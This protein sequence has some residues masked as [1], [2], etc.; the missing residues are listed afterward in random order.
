MKRREKRRGQV[1]VTEKE[2]EHVKIAS[3]DKCA[4][5]K[6]EED[7]Q[8]ENDRCRWWGRGEKEDGHRDREKEEEKRT[9]TGNHACT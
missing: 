8:G 2:Y 7:E 5:V 6:D 9:R 1:E 4:Q 3:S